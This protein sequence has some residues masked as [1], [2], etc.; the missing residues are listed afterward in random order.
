MTKATARQYELMVI[1]KPD[2][3]EK[4]T[5]ELLER[6][7]TLI[8]EEG[9]SINH[10]DLWGKREFRYL[11]KKH[12]EGYYAIFYFMMEKAST[13]A[14]VEE[15]ALEQEIIRK[16]LVAFEKSYTL[17]E[18]LEETKIISEKEDVIEKEKEEKKKATQKKME[19]RISRKTEPKT[20]APAAEATA[21]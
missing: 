20:E 9:G 2:L 1:L 10:E 8:K 19:A 13:K 6:V 11:M 15:L 14:L 12:E 3:T 5:N 4:K 7:R 17:E 16:L 18:Y 21:E